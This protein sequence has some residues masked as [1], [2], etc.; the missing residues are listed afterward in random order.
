MSGEMGTMIRAENPA[1]R[2][3]LIRAT[4]WGD[5]VEKIRGTVPVDDELVRLEWEA[6]GIVDDSGALDRNWATA[7]RVTQEAVAGAE[8]VS[9]H[10]GVAFS[11]TLFVRDVDL[12][13]VTARATYVEDD[14]GVHIDAVH[15]M[16]EVALAPAVDP[17]LLLRRVLPPVEALRAAPREPG[18]SEV[19]R[20]SL[21]GVVIPPHLRADPTAFAQHLVLLPGLPGAVADAVDAVASVF[22]FVLRADRG[23]VISTSVA[24]A[25]GRQGLYRVEPATASVFSVPAGDV[26]HQLAAALS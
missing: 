24:W 23:E 2:V 12:V 7:L 9:M 1:V 3:G 10:D 11:A 13:C 4:A 18:V 17:W 19:A 20:L 25:A 6:A 16:L 8:V 5:A 15:P 14:D 22:A 21:D 26:G